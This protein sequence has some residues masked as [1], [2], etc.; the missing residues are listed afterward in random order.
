MAWY[1]G[2]T[3]K[4]ALRHRMI[5]TVSCRSA[6]IMGTVSLLLLLFECNSVID[7]IRNG[8]PERAEIQPLAATGSLTR[9]A[10][11]LRASSPALPPVSGC[12]TVARSELSLGLGFP[13]GEPRGRARHPSPGPQLHVT[14]EG[15]YAEA[16]VPGGKLGPSPGAGRFGGAR[17]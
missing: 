10:V 15:H 14:S 4:S 13:V 8:G 1:T 2:S 9:K 16:P 3:I 6:E 11:A 5:K 7:Q 12:V 17:C